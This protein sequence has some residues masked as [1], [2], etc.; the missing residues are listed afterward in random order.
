MCLRPSEAC[1]L[2]HAIMPHTGCRNDMPR[3]P[4]L[5]LTRHA[6]CGSRC[7]LC[8]RGRGS[9]H[10]GV[11]LWRLWWRH[12]LKTPSSAMMTKPLSAS[13]WLG[14]L[15]A[16]HPTLAAYPTQELSSRPDAAALLC[17]CLEVLRGA[18]AAT[19]A[20]TQQPL[21]ALCAGLLGP[22]LALQVHY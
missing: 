17:S 22:L 9:I 3:V 21:W 12:A 11:L 10:A 14:N 18:T 15:E 7:G 5:L 6:W 19:L 13:T 20:R 8:S 16:A 2:E 4:Y 1:T